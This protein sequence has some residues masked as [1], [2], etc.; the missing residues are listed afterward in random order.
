[1]IE[2]A[3]ERKVSGRMVLT[4]LVAFFA[5][6][7]AVNALMATLAI[8]TFGGLEADNAYRAGLEFARELNA[9]KLQE[10]QNVKVDIGTSR[11]ANGNTAFRLT[12]RNADQASLPRL[13][14]KLELR[15]PAA[16]RHDRTVMLSPAGGG[17]FVG[18]LTLDPGQ[19]NVRVSIDRA[20]ERFFR[21]MN[22]IQ[23]P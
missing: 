3:K 20:G 17:V 22:R 19:W 10:A 1:M 15:H 12:V 18:E 4:I 21:S 7:T 9:A 14:A 2:Q 11:L 16:K 8:R 5:V 6:I 23:I 13:V